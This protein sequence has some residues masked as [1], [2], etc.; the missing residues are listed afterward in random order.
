GQGD[1]AAGAETGH[2][3]IRHAAY[4]RALAAGGDGDRERP[5]AILDD[6]AQAAIGVLLDGALRAHVAPRGEEADRPERVLFPVGADDRHVA[7]AR[8]GLVGRARALRARGGIGAERHVA[9]GD[10]AEEGEPPVGEGP[11]A[12]LADVS[13][14]G[15]RLPPA[16]GLAHARRAALVA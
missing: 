8:G 5:L 13:L 7:P 16:V 10:A 6:E 9:V 12:A 14:D 4:L 2:D 3:R 1:A 11:G 15:D